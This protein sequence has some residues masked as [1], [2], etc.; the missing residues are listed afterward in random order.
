MSLRVLRPADLARRLGVSRT[1][2]WRWERSGHLP[3]R[4]EIGPNTAGW[5]EAEIREWLEARPAAGDPRPDD[6]A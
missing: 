4:R 3:R 1:T 2:L 6:A 5:P